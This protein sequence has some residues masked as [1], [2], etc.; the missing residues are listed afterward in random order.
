M[1]QMEQAA[2]KQTQDQLA[3]ADDGA[4]LTG[5]AEAL[6]LWGH[7]AGDAVIVALYDSWLAAHRHATTPP[8]A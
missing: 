8:P 3:K 7:N 5:Q 2:V 1:E 6:S 4:A